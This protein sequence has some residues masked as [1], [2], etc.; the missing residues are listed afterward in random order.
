M[1]KGFLITFLVLFTFGCSDDSLVIQEQGVQSQLQD[2]TQTEGFNED[3]NLYFGDTH[4]HTK[5][6]FDAFIFGTTATLMMP[7]LLLR[8][9]QLNIP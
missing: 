7:I 1:K 2:L 5:Y 6:S 9:V 4:V 3:R 8:E